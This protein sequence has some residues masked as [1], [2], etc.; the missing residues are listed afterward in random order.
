MH[1]ERYLCYACAQMSLALCSEAHH[2]HGEKLVG[3]HM[4]RV[5]VLRRPSGG[6]V[7]GQDVVGE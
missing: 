4:L 5:S 6:P 3:E 1:T 2:S 7:K